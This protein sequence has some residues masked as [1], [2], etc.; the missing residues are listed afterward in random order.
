MRTI[1]GEWQSLKVAALPKN[2]GIIQHQETKR[3]FH[4]GAAAML[5]VLFDISGDEEEM[6]ME[7][8][9]AVLAG[10]W[11]ESEMFFATMGTHEEDR[12]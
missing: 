1:E 9:I 11:E 10:L 8:S 7:A 6:S 4:A 5:G 12:R 2:M 3:A